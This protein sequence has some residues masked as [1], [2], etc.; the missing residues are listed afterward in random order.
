MTNVILY[1]RVSTDEQRDGSSLEVQEQYLRAYCSNH[2][3]NILGIYREDYSAKHYDMK[4][5]E[6]KNIYD[7]CRKHK[8]LVSKVLFLRWDRYSRNVEFAFAYKRKFYDE[9]GIEINAIESPIDFK[10]TE[11]AML[12]AMYCGTAH[13]EDE[14]ISRRTKDGNHGT[15]LKGKWPHKA[16]RGYKNVRV[17]K[18]NCWIEVDEPKAEIIRQLFVE[19]AK[20][21]EA[22]TCIKNRLYPELPDTSFFDMLRNRFYMGDVYVPAYNGDPEQYVTGQHEPIIDKE[23]FWAVQEVIDGN[24]KKTP[25]LGRPVNPNL[26]LRKFLACPICGHPLTGATSKGNGGCYDYYFCNH[27]HKHIN[28]RADEVNKGFVRFISN[29]KPNQAVLNLYNEV[30]QDIRGEATRENKARADKLE[31]QLTTLRSR[32]AAIMDKYLD[33]DLSKEEK[34]QQTERISAQIDKFESQIR[35]LRLSK[36]LRIK[37]KLSYGINLIGNLSNFFQS[38]PYEIKVKLLGSIFPE[39]IVF[40]GKSYRTKSYNKMLDIIYQETKQLRGGKKKKSPKN[41]GD[42]G[43]VPK[44]GL[45]PAR[46]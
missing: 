25:K 5:P 23:T 33:G 19:V 31:E 21:L 14:K 34:M 26:Y 40:D 37:D 7:Y 36:D 30:L 3:L 20:G 18:H 8:G 46:L 10:G 9:L 2:C 12:L 44:A 1:C 41:E 32:Q 13:T 39:T 43:L 4:R 6:M 38:A 35:V 24:K 42:F 11:W 29:L 16:P 15:L 27:D 17:A 45:E 28:R 22:P